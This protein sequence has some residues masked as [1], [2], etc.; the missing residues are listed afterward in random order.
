VDNGRLWC[1]SSAADLMRPLTQ[2]E[3]NGINQ[4]VGVLIERLL[5]KDC[6]EEAKTALI[7]DG[8]TALSK[9]KFNMA[10]AK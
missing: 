10:R 9:V 6:S 8:D 2:N 4:N 1:A 7:I 3:Q 5:V